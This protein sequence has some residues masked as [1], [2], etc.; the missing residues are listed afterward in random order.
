MELGDLRRSRC[1]LITGWASGC[2]LQCPRTGKVRLCRLSQRSSSRCIRNSSSPPKRRRPSS[3]GPFLRELQTSF[4][5]SCSRCVF[6]IPCLTLMFAHASYAG[7]RPSQVLQTTHHTGRKTA[8]LWF[9]GIRDAGR[10]ASSD[11]TAQRRR[12]DA[13]GGWCSVEKA[14]GAPIIPF[15]L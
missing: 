11:C 4:L 14:T 9:R 8:R 2:V 6:S 15:C 5:T 10:G 1:S 7:L 13:P 12:V 3:L